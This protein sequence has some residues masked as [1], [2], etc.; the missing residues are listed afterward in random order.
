MKAFSASERYK[1]EKRDKD[2]GDIQKL[3]EMYP[4]ALQFPGS[5]QAEENK[6]FVRKLVPVLVEHSEWSSEEWLCRLGL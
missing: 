1:E 4:G 6:A 2:I 3:L 5:P